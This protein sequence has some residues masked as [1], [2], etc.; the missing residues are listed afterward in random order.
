M[1]VAN[2]VDSFYTVHVSSTDT[3][4]KKVA[5]LQKFGLPNEQKVLDDVTST[6]DTRQIQ[7]VVGFKENGEL[8]FE[9]VIDPSDEGQQIIQNAFDAGTEITVQVRF[10]HLSSESRQF[11]GLVAEL[12]VDNDDTKKKLR[13]KGKLT[14][15]SD[16]TKTAGSTY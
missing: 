3:D 6:D 7:A 16:I 15:T 11:K 5:H 2:L 8:D 1:A 14:T 4:F 9:Y 10:V 12:S 13:K